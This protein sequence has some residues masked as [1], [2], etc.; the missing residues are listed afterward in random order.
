M[1]TYKLIGLTGQSG[2][3]KSTVSEVFRG[4]GASVIN[5]D[6][7]VSELYASGSPCVKTIAACFGAEV[8]TESG[9]IDRKVLAA[10]AFSS[11][12]N[13]ALLGKLVHPFVTA[14]L[15]ERLRGQSGPV[16]YDAPQLFESGADVICD[17]VVSVVADVDIRLER[18]TE[19]DGISRQKALERINSQLNE[20]F[21]RENADYILENN[22][23]VEALKQNAVML[24]EKIKAEVR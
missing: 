7:L 17:C 14:V 15:F 21:F 9:E 4:R 2:A 6:E 3:G 19:R 24:Y 11:A 18:I 13:T 23:S 16:V 22:E 1:K 12:E 10:R 5:A 8:L 20:A